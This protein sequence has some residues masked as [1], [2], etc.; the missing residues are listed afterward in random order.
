MNNPDSIND[1]KELRLDWYRLYYPMVRKL[2]RDKTGLKSE[3]DVEDIFHDSLIVIIEKMRKN[4]LYL[5]S[6]MSTYLHGIVENKCKEWLRRR[7]KKNTV[8]L[9]NDWEEGEENGYDENKDQ[10]IALL[11]L[12]IEK[13][14]ETRKNIVMGY[15]Y[16]NYKMETIAEKYRFTNSDSVKSQKYKAIMD[17]KNCMPKS[18]HL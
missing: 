11:R 4:E 9:P 3:A 10:L 6:K 7:G 2:V 5:T 1:E 8:T 12:C 17:L 15:Y 18:K 16:A 13:L 14:P